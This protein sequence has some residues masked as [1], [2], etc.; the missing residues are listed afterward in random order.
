MDEESL[1]LRPFYAH[2]WSHR[3]KA[4][5]WGLLG[6]LVAGAVTYTVPPVWRSKAVLLLPIPSADLGALSALGS[7]TGDSDPLFVLQGILQSYPAQKH[8]GDTMGL[9]TTEVGDLLA[10][11]TDGSRQQLSIAV[12]HADSK[13]GTKMV[14]SSLDI[15]YKLSA[16]T[17]LSLAAK[18]AR[19]YGEAVERQEKLVREVEDQTLA[20]QKGSLTAPDPSSPYS[21]LTYM[22]RLQD[23]ELQL[24]TVERQLAVAKDEAEKQASADAQVPSALVANQKW[25]DKLV[26][27]EYDLQVAE[28]RL[29]PMAP[30]VVRLKREIEVA[31]KQIKQEIANEIRSVQQNINPK[32]AELEAQR[33]V[34]E[35]QRAEMVKYSDLAPKEALEFQ[36]LVREAM[37][38]SEVLKELRLKYEAARV[39]AEVERVKYSVLAKPYVEPKP[40]NKTFIRNGLLGMFLGVMLAAMLRWR[41]F[42]RQRAA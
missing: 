6:A 28:T 24:G 9:T 1:D 31:Q 16:D 29:G 12:D 2:L 14:Q 19:L 33:L 34:L 25:R 23:T 15:L 18:Q 17:D 38:R 30:E 10:V 20:F 36:R 7:L 22:R 21:G 5:L 26:Q 13:F 41:A 32:V 27:L 8:V 37:A 11:T 39:G 40:V 4:A 42:G 3:W 35:W